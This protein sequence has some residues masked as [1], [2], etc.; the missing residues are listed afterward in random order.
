MLKKN[1]NTTSR[2]GSPMKKTAR[3][4]YTIDRPMTFKEMREQE[5]LN[6]TAFQAPGAYEEKIKFGDG[7]QKV[8]FGRKYKFT[9]KEGP[10]PGQY[11][12][13]LAQKL[14]KP[15]A[16]EAYIDPNQAKLGEFLDGA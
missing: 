8:D 4:K 13:D 12:P 3:N 16:Y 15:K 5:R 2:F 6:E 7:L 14:V 1:A 11:N 10:P 9:P